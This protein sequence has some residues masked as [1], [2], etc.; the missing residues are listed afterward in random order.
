MP[1]LLVVSLLGALALACTKGQDTAPPPGQVCTRE[2]K[3][4]PDGSA[5]GRTGPNCEFAPCPASAGDPC[6][7]VELPACP[8]A[9]PADAAARCGQPCTQDGEACGDELGDGQKCQ[10]GAWTCSVHPPAGPGCDKVCR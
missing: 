4:C 6:E 3:L 9:C 5:V 7:G 1:R 2:A 8:P 10:G